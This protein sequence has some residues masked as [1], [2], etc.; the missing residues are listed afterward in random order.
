MSRFMRANRFAV[1]VAVFMAVSFLIF[2]LHGVSKVS[3][4]DFMKVQWPMVLVS[5]FFMLVVV[6]ILFAVTFYMLSRCHLKIEKVILEAR[7]AARVE[8]VELAEKMQHKTE[9][10]QLGMSQHSA[11]VVRQVSEVKQKEMNTRSGEGRG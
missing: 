7:E 11:A 1:I 2:F 10:I 9:E 6:I 5:V 3:F 8:R 4:G